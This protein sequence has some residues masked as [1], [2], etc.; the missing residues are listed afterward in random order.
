LAA[1]ARRSALNP[2]DPLAQ[3]YLKQL[4]NGA[5]GTEIVTH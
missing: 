5:V 1:G 2:A 3:Y 4:L